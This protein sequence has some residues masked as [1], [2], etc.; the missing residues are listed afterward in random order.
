MGFI[1]KNPFR[2]RRDSAEDKVATTEYYDRTAIDETGANYR[3]IVGQRS[4]GK[5]YSICKTIIEDYINK[6]K[7]AVYIRRYAEQIVPKNIQSLFNPHL[8]LITQLSGG[9][10][11]WVYYRA[12]CFYLCFMDQDGKIV[13]KDETPFCLTRSVN[14]WETTKGAD[15]GEISLILYDEFLTR[16]SYLKDEFV[17]LMNLLSSIIRDRKD[18]VVYLVANSVNKYAP[19]WE[20]FG[21]EEV[22]KMKQGEIRVYSYPNSS[23]RLAIEYCAKSETTKEVNDSFFAFQNAQLEMLKNGSWEM[24]SYQRAPYKIFE[25]DIVKQFYIY[26]GGQMLCGKIVHPKYKHKND[27]FIFFCRQTKDIQIDD[28]TP[29]YTTS[30]STSVCHVRYLKD[31]PTELHKLINSLIMK[32]SMCFADNEVGEIVRNW[33]KDQGINNLL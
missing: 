13:D 29:F 33:L 30:F 5:T 7:R 27:L 10:W 4:N 11:N 32:N 26:F 16:E 12:N 17:S 22:D 14:T 31:Q 25:E 6:G 9:Q 3:L 8:D 15:V 1:F 21:I 28:L 24:A 18:V 20:E 23:M 19:Y 2:K